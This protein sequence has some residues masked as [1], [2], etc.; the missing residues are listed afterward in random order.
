MIFTATA[1]D[2]KAAAIFGFPRP[3]RQAES[4]CTADSRTA[5]TDMI[6][7]SRTSHTPSSPCTERKR[8][9][10]VSDG[11]AN[12]NAA[13]GTETKSVHLSAK[14]IFFSASAALPFAYN[15]AASGTIAAAR[16]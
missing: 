10:A 6:R 8:R 15:D 4:V 12:K 11:N 3:V 2:I 5:P 7:I 1:A 14:A 9:A 16:P 13:D